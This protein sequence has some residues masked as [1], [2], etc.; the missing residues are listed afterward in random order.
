MKNELYQMMIVNAAN[1]I[2]N[3]DPNKPKD[4]D[5][6]IWQISSV[7]A[8][9]TCKLKKDVIR[10]IVEA[11]NIVE[12]KPLS[13]RERCE[14]FYKIWGVTKINISTKEKFKIT[15]AGLENKKIFQPP[16]YEFKFV[17]YYFNMSSENISHENF[18]AVS[19]QELKLYL[20]SD[21]FKS[22][23]YVWFK[24]D[25]ILE[26]MNY[27]KVPKKKSEIKHNENQELLTL[28]KY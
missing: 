23:E 20:D 2:N 14:L 18:K 16:Q 10:D 21:F 24:Q 13:F 22:S 25:I 9:C 7:I 1:H 6:S 12:D 26:I 19:K 28:D 4:D 5:F 27:Q 15:G 17:D 8:L 3:Q 11:K